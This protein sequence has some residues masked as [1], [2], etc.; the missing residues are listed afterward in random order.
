MIF[1]I[2][3]SIFFFIITLINKGETSQVLSI[4][5]NLDYI[6][7]CRTFSAISMLSDEQ[8]LIATFNSLWE[9]IFSNKYLNLLSSNFY[10]GLSTL[11]ANIHLTIFLKFLLK[12][13]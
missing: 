5:Q 1:F 2:L 13:M 6:K 8:T 12:I 7:N 10:F 3:I 4:C 11:C 9:R